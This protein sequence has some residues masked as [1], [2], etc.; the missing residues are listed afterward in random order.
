MASTVTLETRVAYCAGCSA[1]MREVHGWRWKNEV[2]CWPRLMLVRIGQ[3]GRPAEGILVPRGSRPAIPGCIERMITGCTTQMKKRLEPG[4][5]RSLDRHVEVAVG[6]GDHD[7][8]F[9]SPDAIDVCDCHLSG[10]CRHCELTSPLEFFRFGSFSSQV[11]VFHERAHVLREF[12][13]C[14]R[15]RYWDLRDCAPR[16]VLTPVD[17]S[18]IRGSGVWD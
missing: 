14:H 13:C 10:G 2:L 6:A 11:P 17:G 4:A 5:S 18:L 3:N 16:F 12:H 15:A 7:V 8:V 9:H 1:A